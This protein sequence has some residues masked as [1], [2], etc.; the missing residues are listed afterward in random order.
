M[1][2]IGQSLAI[3]HHLHST[4]LIFISFLVFS[5]SLPMVSEQDETLVWEGVKCE[6]PEC[7]DVEKPELLFSYQPL[8]QDINE[9]K[10]EVM[11]MYI[12][13]QHTIIL[14]EWADIRDYEHECRHACKDDKWDKY[15]HSWIKWERDMSLLIIV[16]A[17]HTVR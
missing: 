15:Y 1:K 11:G 9:R 16:T 6:C 12:P 2:R 3:L 7:Q 5:C 13:S 4:V 8:Y 10:T 17:P 14:R